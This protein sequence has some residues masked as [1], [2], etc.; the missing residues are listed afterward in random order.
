M[1]RQPFIFAL[2]SMLVFL[3]LPKLALAQLVIDVDPSQFR[4]YP[5]AVTALKNFGET[6]DS[7]NLAQEAQKIIMNDLAIAGLFDVLNPKAFLEDPKTAGITEATINFT[8]W[9]Q[10]GAE[11]LIKGGFWIMDKRIKLD[12]RLFDVA[13]GRETLKKTYEG[14]LGALRNMLHAFD[15]EIVKF[16][17]KEEGVFSTKIVSVRLINKRKQIYVMDFDGANGRVLVDNGSIN[18]LPAFSADG[19]HVYFTS[20]MNNNP[21]LFRIPSG[22]GK[23]TTISSYRGLNVGASLSPD[24]KKVA[25]TLSKDGNS[26]IYVMDAEGGNLRRLTN[27]WGIDASPTWAP[28]SH[29]VAFVSDR[30]GTPQIYYQEAAGATAVRL[31][32]Q[33]NYNQSPAWSPKG[34]KITFCGRDERLVFDLFL[35]DVETREIT[36]LT[37]DQGTNEDPTWSPN[38]RHIV[39]TSTRNGGSSIWI[40]NA[41]GTNQRQISSGQGV[42]S[43]PDWSPRF[44]E[45]N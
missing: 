23:A 36:R 30:S 19:A 35:V 21:D 16:F 29:R 3:L 10:V 45:N 12:L 28:D 33:G 22:G 32:F 2:G 4:Q 20:Y 25:V 18:L 8:Q 27:T 31:T 26:E 7:Q 1:G 40:M 42:F 41:D 5:I 17:T 11:G 24:G 39:F 37:Q 14:D 34:D 9:L 44:K 38:G 43:T 15:D 13:L 6:E